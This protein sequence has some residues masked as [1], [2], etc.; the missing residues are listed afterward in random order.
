VPDPFVSVVISTHD[1]PERLRR[2]LDAL[3]AQTLDPSGFE[4][5]VVDDGSPPSTEQVLESEAERSALTLRTLRN[6]HPF[7]PGAG[8]NRGWREARSSLIAF[9]DDDCIPEPRW[10]QALTEAAAQQP[11]AILQGR[12]IPDP[13]ELPGGSPLLTRTVSIDRLG[14][15]YETCNI[16]YPRAVLEELGGFDESYGPRPGGEDTDLAWRSLERGHIALFVPEAVVRH[17]LLHLGVLGALRDGWRWGQCAQLFA[18]HPKARE[19]LYHGVFWNVWHYL[20][21]RS[22]LAMLAPP[23]LRQFVLRRHLAALRRRA[24]AT[25]GGPVWIPFLLLYDAVET[26]SMIRGAAR[27]RTPLL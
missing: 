15:Q 8:R 6:D 19:M 17:A 24:R 13:D 23:G 26:A 9:T 18:R 3:A 16:A 25:G 4:V 1:R 2:L 11:G 7:G 27:H 12:T 21:V 10:L 22:L 20:L 5:V 14:P